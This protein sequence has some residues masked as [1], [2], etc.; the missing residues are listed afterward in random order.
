M[1]MDTEYLNEDM[2]GVRQVALGHL[3]NKDKEIEELK[4]VL[5][6][7]DKGHQLSNTLYKSDLDKNDELWK[8]RF[9]EVKN[10]LCDCKNI[11]SVFKKCHTCKLLDEVQNK[12]LEELNKNG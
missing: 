4:K 10:K 1:V 7:H 3:A 12:N 5:Y 9:D 8:K 2:E 11:S 6:N